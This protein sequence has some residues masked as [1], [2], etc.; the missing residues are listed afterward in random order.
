MYR[1][2]DRLARGFA[3]IGGLALFGLILLTCVSIAGRSLNSLLHSD[4]VEATFPDV[5]STLLAWGIGPIHGDFELVEA[6]MAFA[7]FAFIPLCQLRAGHA[8]VSIFTSA[9][10]ANL[11]RLLSVIIDVLFAVALLIIARQL[12]EGM[13]SKRLTGQVTFLLQFP[14]WWAYAASLT[15]AVAT[16]LVAVYIAIVRVLELFQ[17]RDLLPSPGSAETGSLH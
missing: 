12:Y 1:L 11:N 13:E 16:S 17:A 2:A 5:A 15:G 14:L 7:I 9:L 3:L 8:S 10:P 4:W 6:G